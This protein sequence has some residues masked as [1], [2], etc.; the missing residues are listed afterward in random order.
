MAEANER[1]ALEMLHAWWRDRDEHDAAARIA[2]RYIAS[3]ETAGNLVEGLLAV[4]GVL[5]SRVEATDP[6]N[7]PASEI[8]EE[9]RHRVR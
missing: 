5:L 2:R 4:C 3:G 1:T 9:L 6:T 7:R 8:L